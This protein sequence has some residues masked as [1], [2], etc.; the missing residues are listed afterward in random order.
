MSIESVMPSNHLIHCCCLLSL[1]LVF[2][3]IRVFS[4]ESA[5][6]VRW[7]KDWS[8]SYSIS[9]S[10]EYSGVI[11]FR[12]DWF[13]HLAVQGTFKG[14]QNHSSKASILQSSACFMVQ[15]SHPYVTTEKNIPLTIQTFVSKVIS[16]LFNMLSRFVRVFL[17]KSKCLLISHL[18]SLCTV[19]LEP[20]KIKSVTISIFSPS[21]RHE[22]VGLD[23]MI[24]VF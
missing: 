18:Q 17:P 19:I 2:P 13:N 6:R 9:L 10:S 8:F 24:L 1:L 16:L 23:A 14:L 7:P 22:V 12:K 11:S 15:L 21:I 3:T 20:T 5:L 4:S